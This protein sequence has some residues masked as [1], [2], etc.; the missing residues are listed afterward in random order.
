MRSLCVFC[1]C[2]GFIACSAPTTVVQNNVGAAHQ[3]KSTANM[4]KS[5]ATTS[6]PAGAHSMGMQSNP[7]AGTATV[8][9]ANV[10]VYTFAA[11][12]DDDAASETLYWANDG[13]S[14]YV[15]GTIDLECVDDADNPTG[16]TGTAGF[17][18][19]AD[20][21]GYGWLVGTDSCGYSTLFG[22]SDDGTGETCGGCD[23]D[24]AFIV[25]TAD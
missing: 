19:E 14:V 23:W 16:E 25:C 11:N 7:R 4:V 20:P 22:C 17:V 21:G 3:E 18:Y 10:E 24:D 13:D 6:P 2:L 8:P 1:S 5:F 15:W 12:I 9:I